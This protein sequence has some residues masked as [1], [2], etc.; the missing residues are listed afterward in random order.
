MRRYQKTG[1]ALS[2]RIPPWKGGTRVDKSKGGRSE[3]Q[4]DPSAGDYGSVVI[5]IIILIMSMIMIM[6]CMIMIMIMI[7]MIMM[8]MANDDV[9]DDDDD[10][11]AYYYY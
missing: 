9:V 3:R 7:M 5:M 6:I 4:V 1:S 10:D 8:I 11:D 2:S